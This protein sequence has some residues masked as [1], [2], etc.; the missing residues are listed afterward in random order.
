MSVADLGG[1][2]GGPGGVEEM[3]RHRR[4]LHGVVSNCIGFGPP[5]VVQSRSASTNVFRSRR[6]G[7]GRSLAPCRDQ[8]AVENETASI[9]DS[10]VLNVR[11]L[12]WRTIMLVP[13]PASSTGVVERSRD[14]QPPRMSERWQPVGRP[15]FQDSAAWG[16][17]SPPD[18]RL[19]VHFTRM[20]CVP[21]RDIIPHLEP[22]P[23]RRRNQDVAHRMR[24]PESPKSRRPRCP[25]E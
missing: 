6:R 22:P 23:F 10:V 4:P 2:W 19:P 3:I 21:S 13:S 18:P 1:A 16:A 14:S 12:E 24:L 15:A 25:A 5:L 9:E 8:N 17:V 7:P 11:I 20:S